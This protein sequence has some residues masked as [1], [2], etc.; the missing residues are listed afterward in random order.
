MDN[1]VMN[2]MSAKQGGKGERKKEGEIVWIG[3]LSCKYINS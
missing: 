2:V 3:E 1:M